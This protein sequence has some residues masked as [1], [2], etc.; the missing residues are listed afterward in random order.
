MIDKR[1][2]CEIAGDKGKRILRAEEFSESLLQFP[3]GRPLAANQPGRAGAGSEFLKR[4]MRGGKH[5][6]MAGKAQIIVMRQ[7]E[8]A[9]GVR[10]IPFLKLIHRDKVGMPFFNDRFAGKPAAALH[11]GSETRPFRLDVRVHA[12]PP[13]PLWLFRSDARYIC[14]NHTALSTSTIRPPC[15]A[16]EKTSNPPACLSDAA[17]EAPEAPNRHPRP[18]SGIRQSHQVQYRP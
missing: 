14:A 3:V 6:W 18:P 5:L 9:A 8:I 7:A 1:H 11:H 12:F 13:L 17:R 10:R 16:S 15:L 4:V 2:V